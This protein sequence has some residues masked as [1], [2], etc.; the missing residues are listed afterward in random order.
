MWG[1]S[2]CQMISSGVSCYLAV[3][4]Y[5]VKVGLQILAYRGGW[6][7]IGS[8]VSATMDCPQLVVWII[9]VL[10]GRLL[11]EATI[12]AQDLGLL[13]SASIPLDWALVNLTSSPE[14]FSTS[15]SLLAATIGASAA[16]TFSSLPKLLMGLL[17]SSWR[18]S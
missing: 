11:F 14:N 12:L 4:L 5:N 2:C 15:A 8:S 17:L 1:T 3:C 10:F 18:L 13:G 7:A 9:E 6:A 16:A